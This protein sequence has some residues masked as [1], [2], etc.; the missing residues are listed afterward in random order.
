[1]PKMPKRV[2]AKPL[3]ICRNKMVL[4]VTVDAEIAEIYRD[5]A[6]SCGISVSDICQFAIKRYARE[7]SQ[8][9]HRRRVPV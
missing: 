7:L 2:T 9:Q 6:S 1:M 3:N 4:Y 5:A 8:R